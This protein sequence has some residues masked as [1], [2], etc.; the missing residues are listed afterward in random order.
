VPWGVE[1]RTVR[2]NPTE[3]YSDDVWVPLMKNKMAPRR[4]ASEQEAQRVVESLGAMQRIQARTF[5]IPE[6]NHRL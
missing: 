5:V 3:G 1:I 4:F 6:P 2:N